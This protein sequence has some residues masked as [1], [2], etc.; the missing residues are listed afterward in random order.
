LLSMLDFSLDL[1][2]KEYTAISTWFLSKID[3][4]SI[5]YRQQ[6]KTYSIDSHTISQDNTQYEY[7]RSKP[8]I[9]SLHFLIFSIPNFITYAIQLLSSFSS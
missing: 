3:Y 6:T 2:S 7:Y 5:N 8:P 9:L 4:F 1:Y